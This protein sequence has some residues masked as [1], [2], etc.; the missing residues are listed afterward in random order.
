MFGGSHRGYL[1]K[2]GRKRDIASLRPNP[3]YRIGAFPIFDSGTRGKRFLPPRGAVLHHK[4]E[5]LLDRDE[6]MS[7]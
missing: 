5:F 4:V 3:D 7:L 2:P 6:I 1:V